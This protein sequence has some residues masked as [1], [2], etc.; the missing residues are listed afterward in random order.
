MALEH[1][2]SQ[3]V[4]ATKAGLEWR[5]GK[6]YRNATRARMQLTPVGHARLVASAIKSSTGTVQIR[7]ILR[8]LVFMA[9]APCGLM[10]GAHAIARQKDRPPVDCSLRHRR[11]RLMQSK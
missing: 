11:L 1:R 10:L 9:A 2:R 6:I 8:R 4:I 5:E 7:A 3:A